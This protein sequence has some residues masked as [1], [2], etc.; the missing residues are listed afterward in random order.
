MYYFDTKTL[1]FEA[2]YSEYIKDSF[3]VRE[4]LCTGYYRNGNIRSIGKF[5]HDSPIGLYRRYYYTGAPMDSTYYKINGMPYHKSY[6]WSSDG[7]LR[8]YG[9]YD[10]EGSGAGNVTGYYKDSIVKYVGQY[11]AG[12]LRDSI[13]SYYNK[14]G[15]LQGIDVYDKGELLSYENYD[16]TGAKVNCENDTIILDAGYNVNVYLAKNIRYPNDAK[17]NGQDGSVYIS[18]AVSEEGV[19]EDFFIEKS[20][21]YYSLDNEAMRVIKLLPKWNPG[22]E[23]C[24]PIRIWHTLPV[25]FRLE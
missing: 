2:T 6:E 20:S 13:W 14:D 10:P 11:A 15:S 19:P 7:S 8:F 23:F 21:G 4:G 12:H 16:S 3:Q 18:F 25:T 17:E 22:L 1:R 5:L 24:R 9:E